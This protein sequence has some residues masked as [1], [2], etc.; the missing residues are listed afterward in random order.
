MLVG[1]NHPIRHYVFQRC[2]VELCSNALYS[3]DTDL[4]C[5]YTP[6]TVI[7]SEERGMPTGRSISGFFY[8]F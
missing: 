4:R 6:K 2:L 7:Q 3:R 8:M 1:C 5:Y